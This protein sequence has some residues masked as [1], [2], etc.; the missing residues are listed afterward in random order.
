MN[1]EL[2]PKSAENESAPP[3]TPAPEAARGGGDLEVLLARLMLWGV[4]ASAAVM[5]IGGLIHLWGAGGQPMG[6]HVFRGEPR[7]L[8]DPV[9]I[10]VSAAEGHHRSVIQLGVLLLLLNPLFRVLLAGVGFWRE[11]NRTYVVISFLL[12]IILLYSLWA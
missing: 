3:I 5:L 10:V 12:A 2:N 11:K 4:L 6:D 7:D 1:P 8:R 9:A